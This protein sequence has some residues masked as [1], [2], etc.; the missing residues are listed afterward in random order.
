MVL[1][2]SFIGRVC[3]CMRGRRYSPGVGCAG[4][5]CCG[6]CNMC[7]GPVG[8]RSVLKVCQ[9]CVWCRRDQVLA[10]M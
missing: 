2:G 8:G 7:I 1:V 5:A 4:V 10:W 3:G 9:C 6:K